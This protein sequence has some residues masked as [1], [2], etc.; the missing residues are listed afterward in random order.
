VALKLPSCLQFQPSEW[1][2]FIA[3]VHSL[4]PRHDVSLENKIVQCY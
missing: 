1:K 4:D 3:F 2:F